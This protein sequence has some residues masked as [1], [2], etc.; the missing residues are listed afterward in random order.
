MQLVI[1]YF[2]HINLTLIEISF[3]FITNKITNVHFFLILVDIYS[4]ALVVL[5]TE[6]WF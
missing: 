3:C 4:Y 6:K 5:F 2:I 1:G